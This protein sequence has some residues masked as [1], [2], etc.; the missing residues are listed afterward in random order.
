MT[1]TD[2]IT[3]FN[4]GP[5]LINVTEAVRTSQGPAAGT[6]AAMLA[7]NYDNTKA[8]G[9]AEGAAYIAGGVA[10][11]THGYQDTATNLLYIDVNQDNIFN[12]ADDLVINAGAAVANT[13]II[14]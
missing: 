6:D 3:D 8:V 5:D 13:D 14:V 4:T 12:A 9:L 10:G 1:A 2:I 7:A 11:V